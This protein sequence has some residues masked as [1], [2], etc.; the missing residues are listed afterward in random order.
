M[1]MEV[2]QAAIKDGIDLREIGNRRG[3]ARAIWRRE[4]VVV[5]ER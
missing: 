3:K 2:E 1:A 4:S 5:G